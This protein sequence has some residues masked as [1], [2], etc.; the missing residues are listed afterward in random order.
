MNI[1]ELKNENEIIETQLKPIIKTF[2]ETTF[3]NYKNELDQIKKMMDKLI[4][5]NNDKMKTF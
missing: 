1:E 2:E 5:K 3:S 4:K